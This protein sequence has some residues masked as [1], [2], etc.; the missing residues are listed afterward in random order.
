MNDALRRLCGKYGA[1]DG[2]IRGRVLLAGSAGTVELLPHRTERRFTELRNL[3]RNGTLEGVSTL[4]FASLAAGGSPVALLERECDL[5]EWIGG[6]PV[7]SVFAAGDGERAVNAILKLANDVS[8][9]VEV[10]TG[11]PEGT[12]PVDRHEIIARRGVASDRA[13][14]VQLP[15]SSL[16]VFNGEGEARFSDSDAELFGLA[17][18][19]IRLV[20]AAFCALSVPGTGAEWNRAARRARQ[21]AAGCLESCRSGRPVRFETG[22]AE[23]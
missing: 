8:C 6:A 9:G 7:V 16:Y 1:P 20:R 17:E 10:S 21:L 15:Q 2:T 3:T 12:S 23:A 19:E 4:R 11:L 13:I 22:G 18:E 5:A 14:D